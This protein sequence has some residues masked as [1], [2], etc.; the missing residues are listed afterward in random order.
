MSFNPGSRRGHRHRRRFGALLGLALMLVDVAGAAAVR[1]PAGEAAR[2]LADSRL[3][4]TLSGMRPAGRPANNSAS[5]HVF[6]VLCLPLA[7]AVGTAAAPAL[8]PPLATGGEPLALPPVRGVRIEARRR[9][10]PARA[11]PSELERQSISV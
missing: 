2:L 7:H 3:V 11:P 8:P 6:C 4:C 9:L 5:D 1:P 10:P